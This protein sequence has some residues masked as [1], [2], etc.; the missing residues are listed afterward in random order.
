MDICQ[1]PEFE[2]ENSESNEN[3]NT[4]ESKLTSTCPDGRN[5]RN[6]VCSLLNISALTLEE[7][8]KAQ[9]TAIGTGWEEAV[10][11]WGRTAPNAC[12]WPRK[13]LKKTKGGESSSNCLLCLSL[14]QGSTEVK[15]PLL[16]KQEPG[17]CS[18]TGPIS[19]GKEKK[20]KDPST[21][22][23]PQFPGHPPP[24][25]SASR[26]LTKLCFPTYNQ[27]KKKSLQIKEFIWCLEDWANPEAV[28]PKESKYSRSAERPA[29]F[30]E[31]LP[32]KAFLVLPP[33]KAASPKGLDVLAKKS[34]AQGLYFQPEEKVACALGLKT[35]RRK[36]EKWPQELAMHLKVNNLLP[37]P[38]LGS[39]PPLLAD[40]E[41]C[42]LH[43]SLLA[44]KNP[45]CAPQSRNLRYLAY[46]RLLKTQGLQGYRAKLKGKEARHM[47]SAQKRALTDLALESGPQ[48]L[49]ARLLPRPLLPALTVNRVV[50]PVSSHRFL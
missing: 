19:T 49:E 6:H 21:L 11:G 45:L 3:Q 30:I 8:Q 28:R 48:S 44:E 17:S 37:F 12:I 26:E 7:D 31:P 40:P 9:V 25:S 5:E 33:L 24:P 35:G 1:T 18:E 14:S 15:P 20:E 10:Q 29:A 27:G 23:Q 43:W 36:G 13:K 41:H 4:E 2:F 39:R 16:G 50:I 34:G 32:S 46:L 38:P 22:S 42:Y 47:A